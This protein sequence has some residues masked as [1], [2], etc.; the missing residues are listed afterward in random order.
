MREKDIQIQLYKVVN[1]ENTIDAKIAEKSGISNLNSFTSDNLT[2][3]TNNL[4]ATST[5]KANW[6][7]KANQ[8]DLNTTNV[9]VTKN[10]FDIAN[11]NASLS[12][13]ANEIMKASMLINA[14]NI[15]NITN[16]KVLDIP[17][18]DLNPSVGHPSILYI[19]EGFA[20]FK[21]WMAYT[22]FPAEPREN[23]CVV[24]SNDGE[25][26][27][28]PPWFTNPI[29]SATD[30]I[31]DG[32]SYNSDPDILLMKDGTIGVY[33]RGYK[34]SPKRDVIYLK[35]FS[36]DTLTWSARQIVI[37]IPTFALAPSIL[38][39]NDGSYSMYS[40]D[41]NL[42]TNLQVQRRT[43]FDGIVWSV[44]TSCILSTV[45]TIF[46]WHIEVR[47]VSDGYILLNCDSARH[48]IY[49]KS[50]DGIHFN[51]SSIPLVQS[52]NLGWDNGGYYRS[53]FLVLE[54]NPLK[55][56]VFL[57]GMTD[58]TSSATWRIGSK[59]V[60]KLPIY[61]NRNSANLILNPTL[62]TG[63]SGVATGFTSSNIAGITSTYSIDGGQKIQITASTVASASCIG[64]TITTID[65][66]K[67]YTIS[68]I[69][70][71]LGNVVAHIYIDWY[72][73]ATYLNTT[74]VTAV[75]SYE[76]DLVSNTTITPLANSTKC[77]ISFGILPLAIGNVGS[78]WFKEVVFVAN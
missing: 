73:G 2:Q 32:L 46:S 59:I 67:T 18:Y 30:A 51:G 22:P 36:K 68:A 45:N 10:T 16:P 35:T 55:L 6:N 61:S 60:N 34:S 11:V 77:K 75:S 65:L 1:I 19:Q 52:N 44:P 49:Y 42:A 39:E 25:H 28:N 13:K 54:E 14:T 62:T 71:T 53:S 69:L 26:W 41:T 15:N 5:E 20:G 72:N 57:T 38:L 63:T 58:S 7:A 31:N 40:V 33:W 37:D 29:F 70:K 12:E 47:K 23:P 66:S 17:T 8:L 43:S 21:Y 48:L 56:W 4:Y 50:T 74:D 64:Q 78:G 27:I 3:G 9:N 76:Y 24:V